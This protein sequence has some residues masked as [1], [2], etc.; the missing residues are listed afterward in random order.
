MNSTPCLP[1][2]GTLKPAGDSCYAQAAALSLALK[3]YRMVALSLALKMYRMIA[4]SLALK[5]YRM[6]A[7]CLALQI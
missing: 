1:P 4:P 2:R 5:M 6:I 7:L 3:M